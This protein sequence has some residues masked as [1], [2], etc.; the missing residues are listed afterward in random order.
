MATGNEANISVASSRLDSE[1]SAIRLV[2]RMSDPRAIE[3][4]NYTI[5][6]A[7]KITNAMG[8]TAT[9][10]AILAGLLAISS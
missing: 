4:A 7:E 9:G 2:D 5:G 1:A 10:G 8:S 6:I 3:R